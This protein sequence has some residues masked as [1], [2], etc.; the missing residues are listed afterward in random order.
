MS[1]FM[2]TGANKL[3]YRLVVGDYCRPWT[4]ATSDRGS[5]GLGMGLSSLTR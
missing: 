4:R 1:F 5:L 3:I 2:E